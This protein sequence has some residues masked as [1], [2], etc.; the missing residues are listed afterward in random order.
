MPLLQ[1]KIY[2]PLKQSDIVSRPR[3][4]EALSDIA[5]RKLT[6]ISAPAGFGKTTAVS[7]WVRDSD[8]PACWLSLDSGD[9]DLHQL[10]RYMVLSLQQVDQHI[11]EGVSA[12]LEGSSPPAHDLLLTELINDIAITEDPFILVLDDYHVIE[13]QEVHDAIDYL[14]DHM[15]PLMHLTITTRVDPPLSLSRLRAQGQLVELR[16]AELRFTMKETTAFL[17][18]CMGIALPTEDVSALEDKTEGWIASLQLAALSLKG[19]ENKQEFIA[20]FSGSH[21]YIIDYLVDEVMSAQTDEERDF[22]MGT[23]ILERLHAPLCDE[24]MGISSSR[25]MLE[26][27]DKANMFLI[28]LDDDRSWYRYHHLF[29]EFL[30]QRLLADGPERAAEL[31]VRAADWMNEN[32]FVEQAFK[33][34]LAAS[35]YEKAAEIV[36]PIVL[37]MVGT[38]QLL[39][40][41][42]WTESFPDEVLDQHQWLLLA[43]AYACLMSGDVPSVEPLLKR[44]E[45]RL[46]EISDPEVQSEIIGNVMVIRAFIARGMGRFEEAI[47]LSRNALE[48]L[49]GSGRMV[50]AAAYGNTGFPLYVLGMHAEA[51]PYLLEARNIGPRENP[52]PVLAAV[53]WLGKI[54]EHKSDLDAAEEVYAYINGHA[55]DLGCIS[56]LPV[57]G[58][59][60]LGMGRLFYERNDL[61]Q[62]ET[63]IVEG[64]EDG[65]QGS[66]VA[67]MMMGYGALIKLRQTQGRLDEAD[68]VF[69]KAHALG[70]SAARAFEYTQLASWEA[71]QSLKRGDIKTA[72][73]WAE[74]TLPETT[75]YEFRRQE[76]DRVLAKVLIAG[77]KPSEATELLG[78]LLEAVETDG[79]YG[80]AIGILALLAIAHDKDGKRDE[81]IATLTRAIKLAEPQ[82]YIRTFIDE[83]KPMADLLRVVATEH[84]LTAYIRNLLDAFAAEGSGPERASSLPSSQMTGYLVDPLSER[85]LEVLA[86]MAG[87]QKHQEIADQLFVTINTVRTHTKSIYSK[88][89]VNSKTDAINRG[90]ELELI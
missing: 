89:Q 41:L 5:D 4:I 52:Y 18:D 85:E 6:L 82:G 21:R 24:V 12:A 20:A 48:R 74:A 25:Q 31:H 66:E 50:H 83:G 39:T 75:D 34:A 17:N 88:L 37:S 19:R 7:G 78:R 35:D 28:A 72:S 61:E 14:L 59:G 26:R 27:L 32:E 38:G 73:A 11:G 63:H 8:I 47:E 64:V 55:T 90:R 42:K 68:E 15:P 86:H 43:R 1:T 16:S 49:P 22:L 58:Y 84:S 62:A 76:S 30:S 69:G 2:L 13:S 40:L 9:N 46:G 44:A 70:R 29:S 67:I 81:A 54:A 51:K 33:H 79:R 10:L 23:S 56:P 53:S 77:G 45:T 57:G 87:G 80:D 60:H 3:L 65:E 71:L 36:D